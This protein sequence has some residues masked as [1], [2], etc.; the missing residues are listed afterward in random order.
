MAYIRTVEYDEGGRIQTLIG[1]VHYDNGAVRN[2]SDAGLSAVKYDDGG[3]FRTLLG[4][5]DD[6]VDMTDLPLDANADLI[7]LSEDSGS[8][9]PY[10]PSPI[11]DTTSA[12]ITGQLFPPLSMP[13]PIVS[14]MA[15]PPASSPP[16]VSTGAPSAASAAANQPISVL[17]SILN[18]VKSIFT[19]AK[20]TT[21]P[22]SAGI[23]P[24][25][26][27]VAPA[28]AAASAWLSEYGLP[29]GLGLV[30]VLVVTAGLKA[31]SGGG[32]RKRNP[33]RRNPAELILMGANPSYK[34]HVTGTKT[35]IVR[36]LR[37]DREA[38]DVRS[39]LERQYGKKVTYNRK[40]KRAASRRIYH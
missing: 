24:T 28:G 1:A 6:S 7:P 17:D 13:S 5:G 18:G 20:G 35:N 4:L 38:W 26:A 15:L 3:R 25:I 16:V 19:T 36:N 33:S 22:A 39:D 8:I 27:P 37:D 31:S 32:K 10:T 40:S 29:I 34:F 2:L 30:G 14:S 21:A 23:N 12:D 11:V 9:Y